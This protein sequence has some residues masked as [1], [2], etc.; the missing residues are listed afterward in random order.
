MEDENKMAS[1]IV[2]KVNIHVSYE[3]PLN[4]NADKLGY[5]NPAVSSLHFK[6]LDSG[7]KQVQMEIVDIPESLHTNEVLQR[8]EKMG[9]HRPSAQDLVA[10]AHHKDIA[11]DNILG[12]YDKRILAPCVPWSDPK[13]TD[14][15]PLIP[16]LEGVVRTR[17]VRLV[18]FNYTWD[19]D[20][21]FL[22]IRK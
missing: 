18:L 8:F 3:K 11:I 15:D 10:L 17:R 16:L 4:E 13:A 19:L 7:Q 22:G 6:P 1:Q 9:L 20:Y 12:N 14:G 2:L 5:I 21:L